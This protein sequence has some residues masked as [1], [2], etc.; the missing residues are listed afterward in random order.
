MADFKIILSEP[1]TGR[2]YKVDATGPAA[3]ALIGKRIG[4]EIDGNILGFAGYTLKITGATDK[5]G[6]P[7]RRDLPGPA[8]RRLL[9]SKG[10]GF[11]PVMDGERRRK[12]VRG[13]EISADIVQ[14]NA[15]VKESGAKPLAEYFSQPEAAAE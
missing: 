6:I 1:E 12:S 7:A 9:L 11:H 5:T 3:G 4:D 15:A 13:N 10:V 8:R 2:S 14:I